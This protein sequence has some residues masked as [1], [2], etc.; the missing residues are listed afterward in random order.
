MGE[1][2]SIVVPCYN[3]EN[4]LP[5]FF[6]EIRKVIARMPDLDFEFMLIDDGSS[7]GTLDVIKAYARQNEIVKYIS[8]SRNFGKEAAIY[9]DRKST[10]L[11]SSH[12]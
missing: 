3:E 11:N 7:D 2:I 9:A 8:F 12:R 1:K 6:Q 4:V 5:A 10:R